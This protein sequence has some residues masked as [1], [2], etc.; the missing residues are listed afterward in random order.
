MHFFIFYSAL[1]Q[2][3]ILVDILACWEGV[4]VTV[5]PAAAAPVRGFSPKWA[6]SLPYPKYG[7]G[8]P[9]FI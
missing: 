1:A 9:S 2:Q 8:N 3:R 7:L 6:P 5:R 4:R